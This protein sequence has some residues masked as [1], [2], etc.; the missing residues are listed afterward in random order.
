MRPQSCQHEFTQAGA[1]LLVEILEDFAAHPGFP[2]APDVIGDT[3]G[4]FLRILFG[5]KE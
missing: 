2:E 5:F 4:A 3:I 1:L